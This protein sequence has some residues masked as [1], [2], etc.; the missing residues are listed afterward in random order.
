[1]KKLSAKYMEYM[2]YVN[3]HRFNTERVEF[4]Q[5][6]YASSHNSK[7]AIYEHLESSVILK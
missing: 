1:M 7:H 3:N 2:V 5:S 6:G 4:L